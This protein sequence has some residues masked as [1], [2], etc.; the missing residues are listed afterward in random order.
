MIQINISYTSKW[1]YAS[2]DGELIA[3]SNEAAPFSLF[4]TLFTTLIPP[5]TPPCF[6]EVTFDVPAEIHDIVQPFVTMFKEMLS[7]V[8]ECDHVRSRYLHEDWKR[9]SS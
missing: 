7:G 2:V 4:Q 8:N 9:L 6:S 3:Q 1:F 5:G